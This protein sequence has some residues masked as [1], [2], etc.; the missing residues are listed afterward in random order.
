MYTLSEDETENNL[1]KNHITTNLER[2][3]FW[4]SGSDRSQEGIFIWTSTG[5]PFGFTDWYTGEPNNEFGNEHYNVENFGH[6]VATDRK[7]EFSSGLRLG[8]HLGS[9]IVRCFSHFDTSAAVVKMMISSFGFLLIISVAVQ[10]SLS[11]RSF[12][13]RIFKFEMNRPSPLLPNGGL[14]LT[15][16]GN[17]GV[18]YFPPAT[19]VTTYQGARIFCAE[20]GMHLVT[21]NNEVENTLVFNRGKALKLFGAAST[22]GAW[23]GFRDVGAINYQWVYNNAVST[24][25]Y[26]ATSPTT[27][28]LCANYLGSDVTDPAKSWEA[29]DCTKATL[30]FVCEMEPPCSALVPTNAKHEG[31][32]LNFYTLLGNRDS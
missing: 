9:P 32:S 17:G 12:W 20:R 29:S 15:R 8:N 6:L 26:F 4:T 27:A 2:R 14:T 23:I 3:V 16:L 22:P 21:L 31:D 10:E 1:I 30:S 19:V 18:Y 25:W 24:L 28:G 5:Q 13:P 11:S 7:K